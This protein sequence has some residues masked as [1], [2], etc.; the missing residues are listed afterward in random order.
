MLASLGVAHPL[1]D[2][3]GRNAAFFVAR[4]SPPSDVIV[5]AIVVALLFP[6]MLIALVLAVKRVSRDAGTWL[7]VVI[8]SLLCMMI[9]V[10]MTGRTPIG[11]LPGWLQ[12]L[13]AGVVAALVIFAYWKSTGLRAAVRWGVAIPVAVVGLFF[14]SSVST[15]VVQPASASAS[16]SASISN[17]A[18]IVFIVFDG[19]SLR[20][21]MDDQGRVQ[22]STYP[23]FSRL[24]RDGTW[25]RNAIT[26][27][28]NTELSVPAIL[29]GV[30][31]STDKIPT[32]TDYP[33]NLFTM[34]AGAYDIRAVEPITKLCPKEACGQAADVNT[35][36]HVRWSGL[37]TDLRVVAGHLMLPGDIADGLPPIDETWGGFTTIEGDAV[38][39]DPSANATEFSVREVFGQ[40]VENDRRRAMDEF[41]DGIAIGEEGRPTF[42]FLHAL[43]PHNPWVYLPSGQLHDL[44]DAR[45]TA[46][47]TG[48]R[49]AGDVWDRRWVDDPWLT[50][51]VY[52]LHLL[53]VE[54]ADEVLGQV[55]DRL[56]R[57]GLY[58]E[59]L[60]V[61][62]ADHG[63]TYAPGM[64]L[65]RGASVII[66]D[67]LPI[68]LF[69]KEPNQ[70]R[71]HVDDYRA[72]TTDVL[73]TVAEIIGAETTSEFDGTS[74]VSETRPQR[75][76]TEV[77][78]VDRTVRF[79]AD[80]EAA[81]QGARRRV[82]SFGDEGA[83][84][85]APAGFHGLLHSP[86]E[87]LLHGDAFPSGV[88]LHD[89]GRWEDVDKGAEPL[90][91]S[92]QGLI[93]DES[94]DESVI[95]LALNGEIVAVTRSYINAN[96]DN[97]F[98]AL[99]P[100]TA[101][102]DGVN[103]LVLYGVTGSAPT[104]VLHEAKD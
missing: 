74:L 25:Y 21:L 33:R 65:N 97:Y 72:L 88:S 48:R 10:P 100:P 19:L 63:L 39:G 2:L 102:I 86:T 12:L 78:A 3:L 37:V 57:H 80:S 15:L 96:G 83:F 84:G 53:Q 69:I 58:D 16:A 46:R 36:W 81:M 44:P 66:D 61:V 35:A 62:M 85:L 27:H 23:A 11:R 60:I 22:E 56:E 89:P 103:D 45:L 6:M 104:F 17:P 87:G 1:L 4:D 70:V 24:A 14:A 40:A 101:L 93:R 77:Q 73:P 64:P 31:A 75:A 98:T 41:V 20:D 50:D 99:L 79:G 68:P 9:I 71:G 38:E 90:P 29:S 18:P 94:V 92:V 51:Q 49:S 5:L 42:D 34:L 30:A 28:Y 7:H 67:I 91:V 95:A 43:I 76:Y 55:I 8:S 59:T 32:L 26:T 52:Q 54:Y 82:A 13:L 47:I